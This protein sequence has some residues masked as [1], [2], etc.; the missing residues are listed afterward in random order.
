V[1]VAGRKDKKEMV[2]VGVIG[3]GYWGPNLVRNFAEADGCSVAAVCDTRPER[4]AIVARRYPGVKTLTDWNDLINDPTI[5][6]VAI[7]TP[8]CTHFPLA[9]AALA[10]GKHVLVEKP[11]AMSVDECSRLIDEAESR[12]LTLMVDHTFVYTPAVRKMHEL[13][14]DGSLGELYYYDSVRV[15]LGLFQ[16]DVNVMWDLAVHDLAI[17]S[18]VLPELPVA[19]SATGVSH[20]PGGTENLAYLTL[21]FEST[22]IAHVHVNWLAPVKIRQTF[23]GGSRKMIS[24]D[25]LEPSEKI[26]I[27]D[28]GITLN[29][30]PDNIYQLMVGYRSGDMWAPRLDTSEALSVEI[31]HLLDCIGNGKRP[32]TD[33]EAGLEVVRI[34]ENGSRSM[35]E[36]GHPIEL[37]PR[38]RRALA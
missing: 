21:F 30:Q 26:K 38:L 13:V 32:V 9:M 18:Y 25:D 27:Y 10:A 14:R 37:A 8:V 17:M 4:L 23:L 22:L 12:K 15:N 11:M 28:R 3:Y 1:W 24:Y 35:Q 16:H 31:R 34:L 5:D 20:V 2:R 29:S 33:G 6:L 19:V 7:S 36:R